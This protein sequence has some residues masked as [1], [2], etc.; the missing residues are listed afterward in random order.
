MNARGRRVER[1]AAERRALKE[2][3]EGPT[4]MVV[5][6]HIRKIKPTTKRD[7]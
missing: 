3:R 2:Q 6:E 7:T 5:P 1:R 4:Q